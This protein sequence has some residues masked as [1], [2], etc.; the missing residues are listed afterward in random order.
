M[1]IA[2]V[3]ILIVALI[4]VSAFAV[5]SARVPQK[6]AVELWYNND[7]HYGDTETALALTLQNSIKDCG[8]AVVTLKS[9]PWV[10]YRTNWANQRMPVFLLG[11]YPDYFDSD[12]YVSPFLSIAGAKSLGSFYNN[13]QVDQWIRDQA[14][15]SDPAVR[16]DRFA[17]IQN[18]LATDVPYVPLFS[19]VAQVG[20][21]NGV[22]NF[23]LHPVTIKWFVVNKP[24]ASTL[25]VSTSDKIITLDPASA[26][27][28]FSIEVINQ[29]FD[30][31]LVYDW[32]TT[33]LKPGLAT[34]VPTVAN[35]GI[36]ADGLTYTFHLR[37]G[38]TFHDGT[39][40]TSDVV[41]RSIDRVIRLDL[42]ASAAF[43]LYDVGALTTTGR[44]GSNTAAGTI[45]TP[46]PLTVVFHLARPVSFFNSL[47][48]FSVSAPVPDSYSQ[49]GEQPSTVGNVVGT[50]PYKLTA[51]VP[52]QQV[53][54]DRAFTTY[55][56]ED[57]YNA[58][59]I[60]PIPYMD[61]VVINIRESGIAVKQDIQTK[62]VD[63]AFRTLSPPDLVDLQARQT[64]LGITI[65]LGSSPQIRY[66]VINVNKV[67]D[68]RVRQAIAYSVDRA[69][70]N[71]LVFLGTAT[72]L[73]SM[74]PPE[75]PFSTPV[76]QT[77]YGDANC[78]AANA[79]LSQLGYAVGL[80]GELVASARDR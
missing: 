56:N 62:A 60:G 66:L 27:D 33:E 13:S 61:R 76:F 4:G 70:L 28:F 78:P 29:V 23:E 46:D 12:D 43:L 59:G 38:L 64:S 42:A 21:V 44:G 50:G 53:V 45:E 74:V 31:L 36:S 15:T 1:L 16:A 69:A 71:Q 67:P 57:L 8:K 24:G 14:S 52:N 26:Y 63:V 11:W 34:V 3:A 40:L 79:L 80:H 2:I 7:G 58:D 25:N 35:Q 32:K 72:P 68:V 55:Y 41:K 22:Q 9:D 54:L 51:H 48:A 20:Y 77:Q 19:G 37:S 73:Y 30:T 39:P 47:M 49:T 18:A 65:K 75:M 5:L 10:V 17:K 6:L